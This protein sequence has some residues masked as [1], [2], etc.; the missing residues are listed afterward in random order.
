MKLLPIALA[1][2]V[3]SGS[4]AAA[5]ISD[6]AGD[7]LPSY[8][9]AQGGDLDVL[10]AAVTFDGETFTLRTTLAGNVGT[11]P[12]AFY[13]LGINRGAG[14]ARFGA[15][16]PGILF[17]SVGVFRPGGNSL[18]A[19]L[20]TAPPTITPL[21]AGVLTVSGS[22]LTATLS[23]ALLPST[24]FAPGEYTFNLWPRIGDGSFD[25][26]SDFAPDNS[27]FTADRDIA[28]VPEP[29]TAALLLGGVALISWTRRRAQRAKD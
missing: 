7:F 24:G 13:V 26:I 11:T 2:C 8:S 29:A 16:A 22:T 18:V 23:L 6:P 28:G 15:A 5:P 17:D 25:Q 21:D 1:A 4:A 27:N 10:S 14:V 9:G 19:D 20:S 12:G 3:W